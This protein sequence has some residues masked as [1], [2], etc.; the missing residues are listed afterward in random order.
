VT[1]YVYDGLGRL[2]SETEKVSGTTVFSLAYV[3]DA[4]NN[5]TKMTANDGTVTNYTYDKNNRLT[6]TTETLGSTIKTSM[7]TYDALG[8]NTA[9]TYYMRSSY[10]LFAFHNLTFFVVRGIIKIKRNKRFS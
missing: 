10:D 7:Y 6:K 4:N 3:Y 5:R 8:L 2:T 9:S 1:T